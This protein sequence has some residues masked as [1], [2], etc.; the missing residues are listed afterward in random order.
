MQRYGGD[1]DVLARHLE[2]KVFVGHGTLHFQLYRRARL[3]AQLTAHVG[4]KLLLLLLAFVGERFAVDRKDNVTRTQS[5]LCGR[6]IFV[7]ICKDTVLLFRAIHDGRADAGVFA[8]RHLP[9]VIGVAFRIKLRV[10]V[11]LVEHI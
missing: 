7:E 1:Y 6:H 10:G 11:E 5:R 2:G 8:R 9:Q 3:A 4:G